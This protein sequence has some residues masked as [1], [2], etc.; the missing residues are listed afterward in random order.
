M[1]WI[2]LCMARPFFV[3]SNAIKALAK[4]H[5]STWYRSKSVRCKR[6][7][8]TNRC[9]GFHI[10]MV[11]DQ[12]LSLCQPLSVNP[13]TAAV[14]ADLKAIHPTPIQGVEHGAP[15]REAP[16]SLPGFTMPVG[17]VTDPLA[18]VAMKL[19]K[20]REERSRAR[21]A[22]EATPTNPYSRASA[23]RPDPVET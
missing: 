12:G 2:Q 22:G 23:R 21:A 17:P 1:V 18:A 6:C 10:N 20:Q 9:T 8:V 15:A 14:F 19:R 5:V 3:P 4:A 13:D 7:P 16:V 11:R